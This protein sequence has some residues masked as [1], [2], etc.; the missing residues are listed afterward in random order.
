MMPT[1]AALIAAAVIVALSV[2]LIAWALLRSGRRSRRESWV[3]WVDLDAIEADERTGSEDSSE[4]GAASDEPSKGG[5]A[6]DER[7]ESAAA[8]EPSEGGAAWYETT[9]SAGPPGAPIAPLAD[10]E[11]LIG[12]GDLVAVIDRRGAVVAASASAEQV[13]GWEPG[14]VL[15][16]VGPMRP[17][18]RSNGFDSRSDPFERALDG[19]GLDDVACVI[20]VA[21]GP[22]VALVTTRPVDAG[23]EDMVLMLV[24]VASAG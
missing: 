12:D 10:A 18:G 7:S 2:A 4:G 11:H 23:G 17:V 9:E 16:M 13:L 5:A 22:V 14:A 24:E 19:A 20:D 3:A 15:A 1:A 21:S 6:A 8:D